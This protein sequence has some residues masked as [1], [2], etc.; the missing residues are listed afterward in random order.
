VA[1]INPRWTPYEPSV[2][3]NYSDVLLHC[4]CCWHRSQG[5]RPPSV[6]D[7][8]WEG[9]EGPYGPEILCPG[10]AVTT[11]LRC[12][13]LHPTSA[14]QYRPVHRPHNYHCPCI[15]VRQLFRAR[16]RRGFPRVGR[17][18]TPRDPC[19]AARTHVDVHAGT[20]TIRPA[21]ARRMDG[22]G[23]QESPLQSTGRPLILL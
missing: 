13:A 12:A 6:A 16:Q 23:P 9:R 7:E 2:A 20:E 15:V 4:C 22:Y 8:C 5:P 1:L 10:R 3:T 21:S 11:P 14:E 17:N 19:R 18:T